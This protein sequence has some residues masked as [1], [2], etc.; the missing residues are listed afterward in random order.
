M[1]LSSEMLNTSPEFGNKERTSSTSTPIQCCNGIP[2]WC[3]TA[4]KRKESMNNE[5]KLLAN[6]M[7]TK[8]SKRN[9][10]NLEVNSARL[11]ATESIYKNLLYF[12]AL[13]N[14]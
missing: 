8:Q 14:R 5:T 12:Y 6:Y 4:R 10:Q 3:N 1:I 7:I 13:S 2:I 11:L 9:S